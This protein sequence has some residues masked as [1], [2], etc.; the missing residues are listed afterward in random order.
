MSKSAETIEQVMAR[1]RTSIRDSRSEVSLEAVEDEFVSEAQEER[2]FW[3]RADRAIQAR[4]GATVFEALASGKIAL[5]Y[6]QAGQA[7]AGGDDGLAE[8]LLAQIDQLE[9]KARDL[10]KKHEG[11]R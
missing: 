2:E 5:L 1:L 10:A 6:A 11:R 8:R 4:G 9:A 3:L 7:L